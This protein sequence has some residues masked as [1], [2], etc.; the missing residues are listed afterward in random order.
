MSLTCV[1]KGNLTCLAKVLELH[2]TGSWHAINNKRDKGDSLPVHQSLSNKGLS[3]R[4]GQACTVSH[5]SR[6]LEAVFLSSGWWKRWSRTVKKKRKKNLNEWK[7][8]IFWI[9]STKIIFYQFSKPTTFCNIELIFA[10]IEGGG[11]GALS[12]QTFSFFPQVCISL[13]FSVST[14]SKEEEE[15]IILC[16]FFF[17]SK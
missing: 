5:K 11:R 13:R 7:I 8:Q 14:T 2:C 16:F 15:K 4:I 6:Q 12:I 9:R 3:D 1:F 17:F 10:V